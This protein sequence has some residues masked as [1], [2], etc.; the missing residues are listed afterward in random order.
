MIKAVVFDLWYTLV[1]PRGETVR[2]EFSDRLIGACYARM[3]LPYDYRT[4]MPVFSDVLNTREWH[5]PGAGYAELARRLQI[6]PRFRPDFIRVL[7]EVNARFDPVVYRDVPRA[8]AA[9]RERHLKVGVLTNVQQHDRTILEE[10]GLA[11]FVDAATF[12]FQVGIRK[13]DPR[14]FRMILERLGCSPQEAVMVGDSQDSDIVPARRLGWRALF[15]QRDGGGDLR[16]LRTLPGL[17][18]RWQ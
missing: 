13:P 18:D 17:L 3:G 1:H 16:S 14:I 2:Y 10:T 12:S 4:F 5:P 7:R 8:L 11:R 15:L 9:L 6:P